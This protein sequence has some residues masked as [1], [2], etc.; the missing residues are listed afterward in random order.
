MN[1]HSYIMSCRWWPREAGGYAVLRCGKY[2]GGPRRSLRPRDSTYVS[3][4]WPVNHEFRL[5]MSAGEKCWAV[6]VN[7]SLLFDAH[8]MGP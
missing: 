8:A 6:T 4:V 7:C 3:D 5:T 1:Y 2:V